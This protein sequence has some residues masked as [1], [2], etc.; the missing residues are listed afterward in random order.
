MI[1][2]LG[3]LM[4]I[5][6]QASTRPEGSM[7][8]PTGVD[9]P[10]QSPSSSSPS[11]STPS[12][13]PHPNPPEDVEM[14]DDDEEAQEKK[15][16]EAAKDAGN[17]AYKNRDLDEAIKQFD[18]AWNTWPK[19]LAYLTNLGGIRITIFQICYHGVDLL[20]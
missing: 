14:E 15:A 6:L 8:I 2:V 11:K 13:P 18:L 12:K 9:V 4:G 20:S 16:A 5:D 10:P 19:N 1:D 3:A 17:L 7:D